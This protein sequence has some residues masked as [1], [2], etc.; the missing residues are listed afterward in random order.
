MVENPRFNKFPGLV[1]QTHE[2]DRKR[3]ALITKVL[4]AK[5][6]IRPNSFSIALP[7]D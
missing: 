3:L 1:R 2:M 4:H 7:R 5:A 6:E